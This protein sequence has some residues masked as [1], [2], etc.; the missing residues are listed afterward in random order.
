M[1]RRSRLRMMASLAMIGFSPNLAACRAGASGPLFV[2]QAAALGVDFHHDAFLS[3][4]YHFME[5]A[6][7]GCGMLDYD[8]DGDLDLWFVQGSAAGRSVAPSIPGDTRPKTDRLYKNLLKESG[9]LAFEDVTEAAGIREDGYGMGLAAG[10][11]DNDGDVDV[12]VT[13]F[14]PNALWRNNGDGTFTDVIEASGA[15]EERWSMGAAFLDYDRDGWL[16]LYVS[17]YVSFTLSSHK[18]CY[19]PSG[20]VDYCGPASYPAYSD[21]LL[22]NNGDGSFSDVTG[23]L[24]IGEVA[25]PGLGV[26]AA[27]FNRDGWPDIYVANDGTENLLWINQEGKRFTNQA[28]AAGAALDGSGKP[29]AS[30]GVVADDLDGDGD[31]EIFLTHLTGESNTLYIDDGAG[32]YHDG[33]NAAGLGSSSLPFTGF[34]VAAVDYDGDGWQDLAIANGGVRTVD[35]AAAGQ[36][37]AST[38]LEQF[39]QRNQLM[40][41]LGQGRWEEISAETAGDAFTKPDIHRG[42]AH[43]DLDLD[44]DPDLLVVRVNGP[45]MVLINQ[46]GAPARW[47][48]LRLVDTKDRDASGALATVVTEEGRRLTRRAAFD[49]SYLSVSDPRLLVG[50]G[51]DSPETVEVQWPDGRGERFTWAGRAT[52]TYVDL[53]EGSGE[54]LP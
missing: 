41:A 26:V 4:D 49:G 19:A 29:E 12:Y 16:D 54:E 28:L 8:G 52:E 20:A 15:Q 2:D 5:I 53:K 50:L 40:R 6:G 23:E 25:F 46:Q 35:T 42:M 43:G 38:G 34:G 33:T 18:A 36:T 24:G 1:N 7:F 14:G 51:Q 27:D 48:G 31:M 47:L 17:N 3:G 21:R 13:N 32:L 9:K 30:M 10:D 37:A 44:G 11:Y 22:R 39:W 45:A